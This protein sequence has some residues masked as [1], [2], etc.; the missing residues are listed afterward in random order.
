MSSQYA[1][2]YCA[3]PIWVHLL[4]LF[5][6]S[7]YLG[8][9]SAQLYQENKGPRKLEYILHPYCFVWYDDT[10]WE[11]L[12]NCKSLNRTLQAG[13]VE[14]GSSQEFKPK[15]WYKKRIANFLSFYNGLILWRMPRCQ[16]WRNKHLKVRFCIG[17]TWNVKPALSKGDPIHLSRC[18]NSIDHY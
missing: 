4:F 1:F 3:C 15:H 5:S 14:L 12:E 2:F 11:N 6:S 16:A 10:D 9:G 18:R 7:C 13:Y 17:S 8:L